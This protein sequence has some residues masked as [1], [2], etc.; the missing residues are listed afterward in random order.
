[1]SVKIN[2]VL[3]HLKTFAAALPGMVA[4]RVHLGPI[5]LVKVAMGTQIVIN[6]LREPGE[7]KDDGKIDRSVTLEIGVAMAVDPA[8]STD[9]DIQI[10]A[11]YQPLHAG[12]E[13]MRDGVTSK[14]ATMEEDPQ[15]PSSE[16]VWAQVPIRLKSCTWTVL[17]DRRLGQTD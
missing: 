6:E 2:D 4:E 15:G 13:A 14:F 7:R 10:N 16:I 5:E 12:L 17:F 3:L 8:S 1:M 9:I 11:I